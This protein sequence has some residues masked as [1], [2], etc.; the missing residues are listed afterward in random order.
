[1]SKDKTRYWITHPD[2]WGTGV[3][4]THIYFPLMDGPLEPFLKAEAEG[5]LTIKREI[6]KDDK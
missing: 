5:K 1:M 6:I 4:F 2:P 3:S